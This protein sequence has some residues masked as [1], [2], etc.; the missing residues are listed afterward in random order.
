MAEV[1]NLNL[2]SRRAR[3][4]GTWVAAWAMAV[5]LLVLW[6]TF[7]QVVPVDMV[8]VRQVYFGPGRGIQK[9]PLYGA[10]YWLVIPGYE[11][12]HLFPRD[13][14][15]LDFNENVREASTRTDSDYHRV[16][17]IRIQTSEGYQVTVDITLLYRLDDPYRVLTEVGPGRLYETQVVHARADK[18]FRQVLG[19]LNAEDFFND[20]VRVAKVEEARQALTVDLAEWGL[21]VWAVLLREYT[22]DERYQGAIENRKIQ[23]QKVFK[24]QA[25]SVAASRA[26]ERD[27]VM[28]EGAARIAVE[29]ERGRAEVRKIKA[30]ADLYYRKT[31][32]DGDLLVALADARGTELE[33]TALEVQGAGNLVGM[34]MAEVLKGTQV[35]VLSTTGPNGVNPLDLSKLVGGF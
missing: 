1:V 14:Q 32:A 22:Y 19:A 33:N 27:R 2:P 28:A 11:R 12:L 4:W 9:E 7:A 23:D 10:G 17:A 18:V 34:Q 20:D 24:N 31:V 13:V 35:I 15:T 16:N 29:E 21:S 5:G 8:A 6:W 30:E 26:A 25:E 3:S